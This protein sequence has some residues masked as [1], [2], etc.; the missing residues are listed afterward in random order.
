MGTL[1]SHQRLTLALFT[2]VSAYAPLVAGQA[3]R[4]IDD[5]SPLISYSPADAVT[6]L[7]TTGFDPAKLNNRTIAVLNS[8][9]SASLNMTMEFTGTA[10]WL[11]LA[12]PVPTTARTSIASYTIFLDGAEVLDVGQ[13]PLAARAVYSAPAYSNTSLSLGAHEVTMRINDG[14]TAY[15]DY[16][17]F[18]SDDPIPEA[19]LVPVQPTGSSSVSASK[20]TGTA[21]SVSTGAA[22]PHTAAIAGAIAGGI[23]LL[24]AAFLALLFLRR[25]RC[26]G[27]HPRPIYSSPP[28][29]P[30]CSAKPQIT[31]ESAARRSID[32]LILANKPAGEAPP[33]ALMSS[34]SHTPQQSAPP[35]RVQPHTLEYRPTQEY[36]EDDMTSNTGTSASD[37]DAA[38]R[39]ML[40]EQRAIV[41]EHTRPDPT[42]WGVD[43]KKHL[44]EQD[45]DPQKTQPQT[46]ARTQ[47]LFTPHDTDA[48]SSAAGHPHADPDPVIS[49][50]AAQMRA[51]QAQM[52]RLQVERR[53]PGG[54]S[55]L[56]LQYSSE[57]EVPPPVYTGL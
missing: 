13:T 11:F 19:S 18:T 48:A 49:S 55:P 9:V 31:V 45:N 40:A 42:A 43:E 15:F 51:L 28:N 24:L 33:P 30:G 4:T 41:A 20:S 25:R 46:Q 38:V 54:S 36:D 44:L 7:D 29:R 57:E 35:I 8:T 27:A 52:A 21:A 37:P 10:L 47:I 32:K 5:F 16:A 39:R 14:G 34:A 17:V 12:E 6:H 50:I 26:H 3:N 1:R 2:L 22:K 53:V 23:L 56:Q